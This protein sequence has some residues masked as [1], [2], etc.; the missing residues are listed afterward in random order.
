[1]RVSHDPIYG[2]LATRCGNT[3]NHIPTQPKFR[4]IPPWCVLRPSLPSLNKP[5]DYFFIIIIISFFFHLFP[6]SYVIVCSLQEGNPLHVPVRVTKYLFLFFFFP[7]SP[8][9][10]LSEG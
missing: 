8:L 10:L 2:K 4:P 9:F 6:F 7:F 5:W 3:L 1:M